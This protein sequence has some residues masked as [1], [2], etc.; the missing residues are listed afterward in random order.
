MTL[1]LR[2]A[3]NVKIL[4]VQVNGRLERQGYEQFVSEC[5]RL[6]SQAWKQ[7]LLFEM[8]ALH[9]ED[10]GAI[11]Q[12]AKLSIHHFDDIKKIAMVEETLRAA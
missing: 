2:Q 4:A 11:W 8:A 6:V 9:D 1:Y 3:H 7:S 12:N 10:D 5:E